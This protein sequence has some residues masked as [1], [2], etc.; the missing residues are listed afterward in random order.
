MGSTG[1]KWEYAPIAI[2]FLLILLGIGILIIELQNANLNGYNGSGWLSFYNFW[3]III[4]FCFIAGAFLVVIGIFFWKRI[5]NILSYA[6]LAAGFALIILEVSRLLVQLG[7]N[8]TLSSSGIGW[9]NFQEYW[10][11][12]FF[13]FLMTGILLIILGA[14]LGLQIKNKAGYVAVSVGLVTILF[15]LSLLSTNLATS[16]NYY[17]PNYLFSLKEAWNS[18]ISYSLIAGTLIMIIGAIQLFR[19][20]AKTANLKQ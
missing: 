14:I 9:S 4:S 3:V 17:P 19:T 8:N 11:F 15:G 5:A 2:G 18:T 10:S 20:H 6:L 12:G 13:S 1:S 16:L 7:E